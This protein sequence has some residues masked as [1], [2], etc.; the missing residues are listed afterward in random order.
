VK[1][2]GEAVDKDP[3]QLTDTLLT[4]YVLSG[5]D[6]VSYPFRR[7]KKRAATVALQ[8]GGKMPAFSS[9]VLTDSGQNDELT[10]EARSL[11]VIFMA[12][13]TIRP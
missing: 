2:L 13:Q 5:C 4:C 9:F 8:H 11:F 10:S 7:G 3:L 1:S 6:S 12:E